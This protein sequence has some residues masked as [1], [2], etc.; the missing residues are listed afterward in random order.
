MGGPAGAA[1]GAVVGGLQGLIGQLGKEREDSMKTAASARMT[2]LSA[3]S[4][5]LSALGADARGRLLQWQGSRENRIE[6]LSGNRE[7]LYERLR[8]SRRRLEGFGGDVG[9]QEY[10]YLKSNYERV[11]GEYA[12]ALV[13]EQR[14]RMSPLYDPYGSG[15]FADSFSRRGLGVGPVVDVSSANDRIIEQQTRMVDLLQRIVDASN[16]GV[17][18]GSQRLEDVLRDISDATRIQ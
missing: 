14:E 13:A 12:T 18:M 4:S 8:D 7:S 2:A 15:D 11:S 6:W 16:A 1:I 17:G 9:S 5:A 3:D 10:A